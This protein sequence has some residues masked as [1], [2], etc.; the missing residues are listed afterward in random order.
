MPLSEERRLAED[1][2]IGFLVF[3]V[4]LGNIIGGFALRGSGAE[5]E[6]LWWAMLGAGIVI[7]LLGALCLL[8]VA[9]ASIEE[10]V[11]D[12]ER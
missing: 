9:V 4:G 8:A 2:A 6:S 10:E 7:G 12:A 1:W 5:A 11:P 3:A